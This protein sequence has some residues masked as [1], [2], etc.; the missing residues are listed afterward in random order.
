M[1]GRLKLQVVVALL[2]GA[3]FAGPLRAGMITYELTADTSS[4]FQGP[5]GFVNIDLTAATPPSSASVSLTVSGVSTDGTLGAVGTMLG[6]A[7]GDLTTPG[8]V[9]MNNTM[10]N[11]VLTQDFTVHSFFDVFVEIQGSEIGAGATGPFSGTQISIGFLDSKGTNG[12]AFFTVNSDGTISE[13][14]NGIITVTPVALPEP[15]SVT[16]LCTGTL[17]A[18]GWLSRRRAA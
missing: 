17:L 3:L 13:S 8:G 16:L 14:S 7:A 4:L 18:C 10:A 11:N 1:S 2:A 9:T 12:G 6:T 15:A 5:G